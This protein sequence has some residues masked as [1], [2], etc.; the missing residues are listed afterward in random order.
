MELAVR[1]YA[2]GVVVPDDAEYLAIVGEM[3]EHPMVQMMQEYTQHGETNCL[4]H[5]IAV[6]YRSFLTCKKYGLDEKA[7]AR[8]GLLHDL[9]LYDWHRRYEETGDMFHGLT[10]PKAALENAEKEFDLNDKERDIII[11]HMWPLTP[12]P[13]RYKE[14]FVVLYHDKICSMRETMRRPVL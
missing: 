5:C 8:A 10:H 13:P 2:N 11:K 14:T 7:A 1:S 6:S 12:V 4:A 3:L 9:F